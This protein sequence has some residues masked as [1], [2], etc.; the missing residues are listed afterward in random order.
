MTMRASS[1]PLKWTAVITL[2]LLIVVPSAS[3]G[4]RCTSHF[5]ELRT[6]VEKAG[7]RATPDDL[8]ARA[9]AE[10][11]AIERVLWIDEADHHRRRLEMVGAA[12]GLTRLDAIDVELLSLFNQLRSFLTKIFFVIIFVINSVFSFPR[13]IKIE[14]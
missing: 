8:T 10:E 13:H 9:L 2:G 3:A 1:H 11:L 4:D 6:F 14:S 5:P 7:S 12:V